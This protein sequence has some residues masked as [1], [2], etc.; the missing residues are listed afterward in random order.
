M[1]LGAVAHVL[2]FALVWWPVATALPW[3]AV[4]WIAPLVGSIGLWRR[5]PAQFRLALAGGFTVA[6]WSA[7]P[8][9]SYL[10]LAG[11]VVLLWSWDVGML[12]I[13]LRV[14]GKVEELRELWSAQLLRASAIAAVA[15]LAGFAVF[16]LRVD[17]S[18]WALAGVLLAAWLAVG[19]LHRQ[20]AALQGSGDSANGNRS[21]S[22]PPGIK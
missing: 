22:S 6:C 2:G 3:S 5:S 7:W 8:Q 18:F 21:S 17:L 9:G 16:H 19:W 20:A 15:L 12:A 4:A 10:S 13:R 14:A 11:T 1:I